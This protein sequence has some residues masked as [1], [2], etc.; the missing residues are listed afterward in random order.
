MSAP[1]RASDDHR[2]EPSAGETDERAVA[3]ESA[4]AKT[5]RHDDLYVDQ[6]GDRLSSQGPRPSP[7]VAAPRDPSALILPVVVP[8]PSSLPPLRREASEVHRLPL[9][10]RHRDRDDAISVPPAPPAYPPEAYAEFEQD[11]FDGESTAVEDPGELSSESTQ[12]LRDAP[13][14]PML[15]VEAGRDQGR[16]YVLLEGETTIGRGIDNEVILA[17][18]SVSRRHVRVVREGDAFTLRDM[19]SGNGTMVNGRR[20]HGTT[21][22]D[23]DRIELGETV[24][25]LRIP[26]PEDATLTSD[27]QRTLETTPV[28]AE[29]ASDAEAR[30]VPPASSAYPPE[31]WIS[32]HNERKPSTVVLSRRALVLAAAVIAIAASL[33]GAVLVTWIST[34]TTTPRMATLPV[35]PIAATAPARIGVGVA[36]APLPLAPAA[37][38]ATSLPV[39]AQPSEAAATPETAQPSSVH[40]ATLQPSV[41]EATA[42]AGAATAQPAVTAQP[43]AIAQPTAVVQPTASA[44]PIAQPTAVAEPTADVAEARPAS[45]PGARSSSQPTASAARGS[46]SAARSPSAATSRGPRVEG[47]GPARREAGAEG[48]RSAPASRVASR[49]A[50]PSG[51]PARRGA[52]GSSTQ[53]APAEPASARSA[54]AASEPPAGAPARGPAVPDAVLAPY[55]AGDFAAAARAARAADHD[56][57][58]RNIEQFATHHR[59]S[60]SASDGS[61]A[62]ISALERAIALDNQIV[63]GGHYVARLRPQLVAAYLEAAEASISSRP[64]D[65][66]HRVQQALR[67]DGAS[68]RAQAMSRQ[69]ETHATRILAEADAAARTDPTRARTLYQS[70]L[71]IVS[72]RSASY[73]RARQ[74]ID[75]LARSR[76]VDEDE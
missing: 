41:P 47:A 57:L 16:E 71:P 19:G 3:I 37:G 74:G 25:V 20:V 58:A 18:V 7:R 36:S 28:V 61:S 22:V 30:A 62:Q 14:P 10:E 39:G 53:D 72:Q 9:E 24:M 46:A 12:I 76:R 44:Q 65:G 70:V 60:S 27:T 52:R 2:V 8:R 59:T 6:L 56:P 50:E 48:S 42:A 45:A 63:R 34:A 51:S 43:A 17:D 15:V 13:R 31:T 4:A 38:Q 23:G 21:L 66:C 35:E 40:A 32:T 5:E 67:L 68:S 54:Q 26:E 69:C 49:T 64:E 11:E 33:L 75:Q 1:P 29:P 73:S 55:R